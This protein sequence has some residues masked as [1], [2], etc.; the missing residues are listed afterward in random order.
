MPIIPLLKISERKS[1]RS[2]SCPVKRPETGNRYGQRSTPDIPYAAGVPTE[3]HLLKSGNSASISI[4]K[5]RFPFLVQSLGP[6]IENVWLI[7]RVAGKPDKFTV[8]IQI[9]ATN[10]N[11]ALVDKKELGLY[12]KITQERITQA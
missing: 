3:W 12:A 5:K 10:T 2:C 6:T 1:Q 9:G 7:A 11:V 8:G 4:T